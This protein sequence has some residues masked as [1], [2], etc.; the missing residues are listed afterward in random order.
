LSE[1]GDIELL[2]F[3]QLEFQSYVGFSQLG[4]LHLESGLIDTGVVKLHG[5]GV[6][7]DLQSRI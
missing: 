3:L 7:S 1:R 4:D 6:Q 2:Q 5:N